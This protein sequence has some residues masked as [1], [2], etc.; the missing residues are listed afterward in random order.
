MT[1]APERR[2]P[3]PRPAP[4]TALTR[5]EAELV[6]LLILADGGAVCP[7]VPGASR[8]A[9]RLRAKGLAI[10]RNHAVHGRPDPG[11]RLVAVPPDH[12]LGDVLAILDEWRGYGPRPIPPYEHRCG[13]GLHVRAPETTLPFARRRGWLKDRACAPCAEACL[14]R[15]R[16]RTRRAA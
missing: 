16:R 11:Y 3:A 2:P 5:A 12:A 4:T 14:E 6:A 9:S 7:L 13:S 15:E 1:L 10:P 8:H